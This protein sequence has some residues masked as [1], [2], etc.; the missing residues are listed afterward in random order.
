VFTANDVDGKIIEL[1]EGV[2]DF[3]P[4]RTPRRKFMIH[5]EKTTIRGTAGATV[6][7]ENFQFLIGPLLRWGHAFASSNSCCA[8]LNARCP[9]VRAPS[10]QVRS[11]NAQARLLGAQLRSRSAQLQVQSAQFRARRS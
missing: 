4:L 6:I 2:Y 1:Q 3:S 11:Q 10:A 7:L 5:G 8:P 9:H